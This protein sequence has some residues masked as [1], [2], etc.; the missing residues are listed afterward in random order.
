MYF[1][2]T[3]FLCLILLST[4]VISYGIEDGVLVS[5]GGLTESNTL[6]VTPIQDLQATSIPITL[7]GNA[8]SPSGL[9][10]NFI[11][12]GVDMFYVDPEDNFIW[13][14]NLA[15]GVSAVYSAI[16]I[17]DITTSVYCTYLAMRS[18]GT[19]FCIF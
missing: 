3:A 4:V 11:F 19:L 14:R 8:T 7:T 18:D 12:S 2:C 15:T 16:S 17:G 13:S 6:S 1:K 9:F 10:F 5:I